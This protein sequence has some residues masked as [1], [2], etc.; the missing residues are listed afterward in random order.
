MPYMYDHNHQNPT[1][2]IKEGGGVGAKKEKKRGGNTSA[3]LGS[4]DGLSLL[5]PQRYAS[6]WA[7]CLQCL[8]MT[9][10]YF[11]ISIYLSLIDLCY[12]HLL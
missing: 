8:V 5:L 11:D 9:C 12:Y 2:N 7:F 3:Y 1:Y 6:R 10:E 4:V